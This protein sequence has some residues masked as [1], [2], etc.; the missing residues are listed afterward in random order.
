MAKLRNL[1]EYPPRK[2][3]EC[4]RCHGRGIINLRGMVSSDDCP[5]CSIDTRG[6]R[7]E[8]DFEEFE[9]QVSKIFL[10]E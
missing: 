4:K 6:K 1:L 10:G 5:E 9:K 2:L 3:V 8:I 7:S